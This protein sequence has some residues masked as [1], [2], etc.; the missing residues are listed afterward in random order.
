MS[1][2]RKIIRHPHGLY[3]TANTRPW[4]HNIRTKKSNHSLVRLVLTC[5]RNSLSPALTNITRIPVMV[6]QGPL[7]STFIE[8]IVVTTVLAV[9]YVHYPI[10]YHSQTDRGTYNFGYD[11]GLFGAHSFRKEHRDES[12]IVRGRYGYTD[13]HGKLRIIHYEAGTFGYHAWGDVY[14]DGWP[15]SHLPENSLHFSGSSSGQHSSQTTK[16]MASPVPSPIRF[17]ESSNVLQ[18]YIHSTEN[19]FINSE[20]KTTK[21]PQSSFERR[22][23]SPPTVPNIDQ[24][25]KPRSSFLKTAQSSN[26]Y[27]FLPSITF[28]HSFERPSLRR[29]EGSAARSNGY[30]RTILEI[31]VDNSKRTEGTEHNTDD[32]ISPKSSNQITTVN[33][34][35]RVNIPK[36]TD[37][38][39]G[40]Y[41]NE[42]GIEVSSGIVNKKEILMSNTDNIE[43]SSTRRHVSKTSNMKNVNDVNGPRNK[44]NKNQWIIHV[45]NTEVPTN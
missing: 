4:L 22:H 30:S 24:F 11:T 12:G 35:N 43:V 14:P 3:L 21:Y 19:D 5:R 32:F 15:Q 9:D 10:Q 13:P 44:N 37:K 1:M 29:S 2:K 33:I 34:K 39:G 18:A 26:W 28:L 42:N 6:D 40:S 8:L 27:K 45:G 16:I 36:T 7:F 41:W 17:S 38:K 25:Q 20:H 23:I 31:N